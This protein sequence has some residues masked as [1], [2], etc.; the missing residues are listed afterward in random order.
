MY[1]CINAYFTKVADK[2]TIEDIQDLCNDDDSDDE[3]DKEATIN[4]D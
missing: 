2:L 3:L 1:I 4:I